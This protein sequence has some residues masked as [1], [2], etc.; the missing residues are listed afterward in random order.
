MLLHTGVL[1]LETRA[2]MT[3]KQ[4]DEGS[5]LQSESVGF[6]STDSNEMSSIVDTGTIPI[7]IIQP[8]SPVLEPLLKRSGES[9]QRKI[10]GHR[11]PG[12]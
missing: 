2:I 6:D 3:R 1:L 9:P 11:L 8:E 7:I 5:S 12:E 4:L 10:Q